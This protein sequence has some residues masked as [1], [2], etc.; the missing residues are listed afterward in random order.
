MKITDKIRGASKHSVEKNFPVLV[1]IP[2]QTLSKM[3]SFIA[4]ANKQLA[5]QN[6]KLTQQGVLLA[7]LENFLDDQD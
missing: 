4:N 7:A 5:K 6:L 1:R 2:P 3:R